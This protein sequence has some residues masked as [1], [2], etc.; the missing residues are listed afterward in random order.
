MTSILAEAETLVAERRARYGEPIDHWTRTIGMVNA[1][2]GT[3]FVPEDWALIMSCDKLARERGPVPDRDNPIDIAGYLHG[4][5]QI[6]AKKSPKLGDFDSPF[7]CSAREVE[8]IWRALSD[9]R[10]EYFSPSDGIV[11]PASRINNSVPPPR[12]LFGIPVHV[13]RRMPSNQFAI[14]TCVGSVVVGSFD[15]TIDR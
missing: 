6:R 11:L 2:F 1:L 4:R 12:T 14:R 13:D 5:D 10:V 8:V 3:S 15:A 9:A 7:N